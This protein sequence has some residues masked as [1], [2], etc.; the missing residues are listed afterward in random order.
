M[1]SPASISSP[2]TTI[3]TD[4]RNTFKHTNVPSRKKPSTPNHEKKRPH[5]NTTVKAQNFNESNTTITTATSNTSTYYSNTSVPTMN[6]MHTGTSSIPSP[7]FD[8]STSSATTSN[9][10]QH[11]PNR[12]YSS[13]VQVAVRIRPLL[14]F[15]HGND[16]IL[17]VY[18]S[19]T[20]PIHN[21]NHHNDYPGILKAVSSDST[22]STFAQNNNQAFNDDSRHTLSHG[23]SA[24]DSYT[25]YDSVQV[26]NVHSNPLDLDNISIKNKNPSYTFDHVFP[27]SIEQ[28]EVYEKCVTPLVMSCI[29]GFN[30]TVLAYGQT[31]SG[32]THTILGE[33]SGNI[34]DV[35]GTRANEGVIPRA[36]KQ[37]FN[38]L[39]AMKDEE[40]R[41]MRDEND[42]DGEN[43]VEDDDGIIHKNSEKASSD[44]SRT[45][46]RS[47]NDN[48]NFVPFEYQVKIQFIELYGEDV[49]DLLDHRSSST[50]PSDHHYHNDNAS[51]ASRRMRR[52]R[53][54]E[55]DHSSSSLS[56]NTSQHSYI[57]LP[58]NRNPNIGGG[59]GITI[60]DGKKGED[61]EVLGALQLKVTNAEEALEHLL[62]GLTKRVVGKTAMNAHSSRSHAIFTV[63]IQQTRR[64]KQLDFSSKK[65]DVEMK[66]SKIH[67]V[68]LSGS[69]RIKRSQTEGKR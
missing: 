34:D 65:I 29:E 10:H 60:R 37:I 48:S 20:A 24:A 23:L 46:N 26:M 43:D 56:L 9:F 35:E 47:R 38:E 36:L 4:L 41:R 6:Y 15:E 11:H 49:R 2:T 63:V 32:K 58:L 1:D 57:S 66:T 19:N 18:P 45:T 17:N 12:Q 69:E 13:A 27:S 68:D 52:P 61:A 3:V 54:I 33:C 16:D 39:E 28:M 67:F 62:I 21:Y 7:S 59:S 50:M 64:V 55:R 8:Y 22:I 42:D 44:R 51:I 31:G 25:I 14:Q 5:S 30:A 40:M 53:R